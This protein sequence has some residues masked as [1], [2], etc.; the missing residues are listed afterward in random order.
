MHTVTEQASSLPVRL[1]TGHFGTDVPIT[2]S[3]S[4][5]SYFAIVSHYV[6]A[7]LLGKPCRICI[8]IVSA[9][10]EI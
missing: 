3:G 1:E 10:I 9:V 8:G 4:A 5:V 6:P 7:V 2:L